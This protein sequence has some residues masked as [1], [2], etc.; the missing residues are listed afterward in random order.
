MTE[1]H[2]VETGLFQLPRQAA[3]WWLAELSSLVPERVAQWLTD[4]GHR[5]LLL[6]P[7]TETIRLLL[8]DDRGRVLA[9]TSIAPTSDLA[10]AIETFLAGHRLK[11]R[12]VAIGLAV[13]AEK[14]FLRNIPLPR[15]VERSVGAIAF[16]DLLQLP[17]ILPFL[18]E[19][20]VKGIDTQ[21]YPPDSAAASCG[22]N[23]LDV[24]ARVGPAIF[25]FRFF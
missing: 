2:N 9:Q 25:L 22:E 6:V 12:D 20:I 17:R 13:S 10:I 1:G 21:S 24:P 8:R 19:Q 23:I 15:E 5:N 16:N 11:K 7:E 4:A 14:F 3:E 18:T